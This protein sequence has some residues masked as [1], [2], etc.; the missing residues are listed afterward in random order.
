MSPQNSPAQN[1]PPK[2]PT[3]RRNF[4]W[5]LLGYGLYSAC[6]WLMYSAIAKM[7]TKDQV[8]QYALGIAVTQPIVSL[9]MLQLRAVQ[10]TDAKREYRFGDYFALRLICLAVA[11]LLI[12]GLSAHGSYSQ[13][14]LLVILLTGIGAAFDAVSDLF[15]GVFQQTQ[16]FERM[17]AS[18]GMKGPLSLLGLMVGIHLTHSVVW[19]VCGSALA[20]LIVLAAYDFPAGRR[21]L[22]EAAQDAPPGTQGT[23]AD[24][25]TWKPHWQPRIL[26]QL[27]W[28]GLPLGITIWLMMLNTNVPR[29]FIEHYLGEGKL[30]LFAAT[31]SVINAGRTVVIALGLSAVPRLSRLYVDAQ[32]RDFRTL[33][34]K[35][36]AV[37]AVLG[38]AAPL[39]ALVAGRPIL[40]LLY[41][42]EY[43]RQTHLFFLIMLGGGISY[44]AGFFGYGITAARQFKIQVAWYGVTTAAAALSAWCL[45][46]TRGLEGAALS[47]IISMGVQFISG[48]GILLWL[49]RR[50]DNAQAV[51]K[52]LGG[53]ANAEAYSQEREPQP[54]S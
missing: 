51:K 25:V 16:K 46:P 30:G 27:F 34:L 36:M 43:A 23:G 20:S 40:T 12:F 14:T 29:Y 38:I 21:T 1:S 45:V 28:L 5:T 35:M 50:L 6:N 17:A 33:M 44:V 7:G 49:F 18:Q 4:S 48:L 42:P 15:Q 19:G 32:A 39:V 9:A 52:R 53:Q 8:G 10:A 37:G 22:R 54:A 13:E 47:V 11:M 2:T 26:A 3:M 24:Y 41:T 31:A